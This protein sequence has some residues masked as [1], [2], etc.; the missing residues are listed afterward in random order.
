MSLILRCLLSF[1]FTGNLLCPV[2]AYAQLRFKV[3]V[4]VWPLE[5][6]DLLLG[7]LTVSPLP[8]ACAFLLFSPCRAFF[9]FFGVRC[10]LFSLRIEG[11]ND[12]FGGNISFPP[13]L[14]GHIVPCFWDTPCSFFFLLLSF[15]VFFLV[16]FSF[17]WWV[18][19]GTYSVPY[20]A[21][22]AFFFVYWAFALPSLCLCTIK[23]QGV[24][25]CLAT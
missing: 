12:A 23:I 11:T 21:L 20:F 17:F 1:L 4:P 14:F 16:C 10:V 15:F 13:E 8:L 2:C 5:P 22:F 9:P 6:K 19:W 3:L 24:G 7:V 25:S 18:R